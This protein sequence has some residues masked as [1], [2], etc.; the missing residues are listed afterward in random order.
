MPVHQLLR[1]RTDEPHSH[2]R[3]E[4]GPGHL[5]DRRRPASGRTG[6]RSSIRATTHTA[7]AA[8]CRAT[9]H[10]YPF[11][12]KATNYG[13]GAAGSVTIAPVNKG[14]ITV[15]RV[16]RS[17]GYRSFVDSGSGSSVDVYFHGHRH[18]IKF[19]AEIND[20]HS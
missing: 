4:R 6:K 7:T 1:R 15:V 20:S 11:P 8:S 13:A 17:P 10:N 9:H 14:T 2:S 3:R 12:A 18:A 5:G 19:E 16:H